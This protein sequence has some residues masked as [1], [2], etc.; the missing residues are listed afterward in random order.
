MIALGID[1]YV[2]F[3]KKRAKDILKIELHKRRIDHLIREN[4]ISTMN[5]VFQT[6]EKERRFLAQ[7][8]HDRLG[9]MLF[10]LKLQFIHHNKQAKSSQTALGAETIKLLDDVVQE[11]RNI[12]HELDKAELS[13]FSFKPA[14]I[15]LKKQMEGISD[16]QFDITI[17]RTD[18]ITLSTHGLELYRICQELVSNTLKHAH[19]SQIKVQV[20]HR[21]TQFIL[22]YS[23][24]GIGFDS[25][26]Y[27][28]SSG[29][30]LTSIQNRVERI[31]GVS[32]LKSKPG[33]GMQFKIVI[34]LYNEQDKS[35]TRRRS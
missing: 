24:D 14:L 23:D 5:A 4:E 10:S 7:E 8:I 31:K 9:S 22:E 3:R 32:E 34:R 2:V 28:G 16:T 1:L 33:E 19:A 25:G 12:S 21:P 30:G 27:T 35:R 15:R 17:D 18:S 13:H 11:V 20:L 29:L 6:Q 26:V